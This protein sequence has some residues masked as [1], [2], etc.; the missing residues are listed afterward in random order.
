MEPAI[1]PLGDI[2]FCLEFSFILDWSKAVFPKVPGKIFSQ[3]FSL[4]AIFFY[5]YFQ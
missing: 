2:P 4:L 5:N 3:Y 1:S